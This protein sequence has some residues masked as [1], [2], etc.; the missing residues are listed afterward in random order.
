A[1]RLLRQA[2]SAYEAPAPAAVAKPVATAEVVVDVVGAVR[3]AGL[4]HLPQGSRIADAV[5]RA[6]GATRKADLA[7]VN[8]AAPVA[9]GEQVVVPVAGQALPG[10]AASSA[11]VT[12]GAG[13]PPPKTNLNTATQAQLEELPGVGPKLAQRVLAYR[14]RKG[15][16]TSTRDLLEVEGFGPKKLAALQDQLSVG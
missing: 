7:Q 3:R 11:P 13:G 15:R 14:Q 5:A 2:G 16:F 4:Y 12:A 8:L 1:N 6:G 9:D 10:P